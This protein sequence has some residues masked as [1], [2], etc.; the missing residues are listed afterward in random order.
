MKAIEINFN[1]DR[2]VLRQF[3]FIALVVFGALGALVLWHGRLFGLGLGS[4]ARPAA[5]V[6]WAVGLASGVLSVIR[7]EGNRLLYVGLSAVTYPIGLVVSY[8]LMGAIFFGLL[9]PVNLIFRLL[10][11]DA[12]SRAFAPRAESY[13]IRRTGL[14]PVARYFRQF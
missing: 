13:W 8:V 1:P 7:P 3:G 5:T 14:P 2:R 9:T 12:L 4:W 11:R 6:L 10:G